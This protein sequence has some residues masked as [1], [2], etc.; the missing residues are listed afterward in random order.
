MYHSNSSRPHL[1]I[2]KV[3]E[4]RRL[5]ARFFNQWNLDLKSGDEKDWNKHDSIIEGKETSD[6]H[7][8]SSSWNRSSCLRTVQAV[9]V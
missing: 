7:T 4:S 5:P 6:D 1:C 9:F 8:G 2:G 3:T